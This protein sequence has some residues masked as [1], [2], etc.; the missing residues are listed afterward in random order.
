MTSIAH[1]EEPG[2]PIETA[3]LKGFEA[4]RMLRCAWSDRHTLMADL[5]SLPDAQY[6]YMANSP[7]YCIGLR[8][9]AGEGRVLDGG[10]GKAAY[11]WAIIEAKYSTINTGV[12][13]NIIVTEN[14]SDWLEAR[15]ASATNLKWADDK[16][17]D[18]RDVPPLVV[19]GYE[20]TLTYH[21]LNAIPS[22]VWTLPGTVNSATYASKLLGVSW[23]AGYLLYV[24]GEHHASVTSGGVV[25][26]TVTQR[27][28]YSPFGWNNAFR[29]SDGTW[30][31]IKKA[32]GSAYKP[33]AE[34]NWSGV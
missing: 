14:L 31:A 10:D 23:N 21:F 33:Y 29:P 2:Y 17:V 13:N 6:P 32:D 12:Y 27:A 11:D 25:K 26:Y 28:R 9:V 34:A 19:P 8:C 18:P 7:A 20:Y 22:T 15:P 30:G 24:G 16:A 4:I 1:A 3:N 5:A